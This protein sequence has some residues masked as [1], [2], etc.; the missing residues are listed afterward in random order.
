MIHTEL[1][2]LFTDFWEKKNHKLVPPAPLVLNDDP[3]TL[4]TSSGMQPLV[5]YLSGEPHPSGKRLYNIQP[6]F[7]AV[8]IDEVGDNRHTTFF[9][10]M[11]NWSL[12]DYFK[13][14][15]IPW[16]WYF[17]TRELNLPKEKLYITCFD[18]DGHVSRDS[19]SAEIWMELGISKDHLFFYDASKNWWS[20][21]GTPEQMPTGEIGGPD[22]EVFYEFTD[23]IHDTKFGEHCHPNCDCGRFLEIGNSV[24]IQYR[25]SANSSLEE[26]PQRNV[27]Y[28][29]G[30]ERILMAVNNERDVF[31]TDIFLK[32]IRAVEDIGQLSYS[33]SKVQT[34]FRIIADHVKVATFLI[35]NGVTPS[36]KGH[37]YV[38]RRF[39]RRAAVKMRQLN[40]S[41]NTESFSMIAR[42]VFSTYAD[43]YFDI[44]NDE[45]KTSIIIDEE[46]KRF[47]KSID[48]GIKEIKKYETITG[49]IAF[50]LYQNHGFPLELTREL[51]EEKG[52]KI[53]ISQFESEFKKH[54]E[55]SRS[56]STGMFKGGLA[57]HSEQ[58]VKYHTATHLLHQA[59]RDVLGDS[60][61]QEGSNITGERLR[62]DFS[63]DRK[64]TDE[65][66]EKIEQIINQ[67][68]E[69]NLPVRFEIM[70]REKAD[71]I[72]ALSFFKE[73]YGDEV[74]VYFIGDEGRP[75]GAYSKE[76]CGGPHVTNTSETGPIKI[77]KLKKIGAN[78]WRIYAE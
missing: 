19:E 16:M 37:G 11:G 31:R 52:Q 4:F 53:D 32:I 18:G 41:F 34:A 25:K 13:E 46:I 43:I 2:K 28:G 67:K 62:F 65:E 61:R 30:L 55:L 7:R 6:C 29:G 60:V 17:F 59:L 71:K 74:K 33:D 40:G 49:K 5:P 50:D 8:D 10:M 36:N 38:L 72:G 1:R 15:Q 39:L 12:G 22:T 21:A 75:E 23:V 64:P 66:M 56:T 58:V 51:A 35:K 9:E 54:Q 57:D 78:L 70:P 63:F 68:I 45:I 14:E 47:S 69:E 73:K 77:S 3:T 26:L 42:A 48:G 27:D 20:R 76:F 44:K 24:F